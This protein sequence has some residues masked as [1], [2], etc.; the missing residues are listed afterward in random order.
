MA[1]SGGLVVAEAQS[2]QV[3]QNAGLQQV[4]RRN[5]ELAPPAVA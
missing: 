5:R 2:L 1:D 4:L 3:D